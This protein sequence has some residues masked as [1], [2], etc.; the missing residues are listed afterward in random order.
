MEFIAQ[1]GASDS[2]EEQFS[3]ST[4]VFY[5]SKTVTPKG[6]SLS[7][8]QYKDSKPISPK[9]QKNKKI[10]KITFD[11]HEV[12]DPLVSES[13]DEGSPKL[14]FDSHEV[15]DLQ[16][17][18]NENRCNSRMSSSVSVDL[19]DYLS[20]DTLE[21]SRS[22]T[23]NNMEQDIIEH[24]DIEPKSDAD[25]SIAESEYSLYVPSKDDLKMIN[26][27]ENSDEDSKPI[28]SKPQKYKKKNVRQNL[29]HMR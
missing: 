11:S 9:P 20:N 25:I 1:Y 16:N 5:K 22:P 6:N 14:Q 7:I 13:S 29:I 27:D 21:W 24:D 17:D 28:S 12:D 8:V 4:Q 18:Y 23:P 15:D 10:C 26:S 2:E 19:A 3:M